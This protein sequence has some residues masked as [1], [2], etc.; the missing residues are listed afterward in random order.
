[1]PLVPTADSPQQMG[2]ETDIAATFEAAIL[3]QPAA[4][5]AP[6]PQ[7][8]ATP[9]PEPPTPAAEPPAEDP[10]PKPEP[11]PDPT[12]LPIDDVE[13]PKPD[14]TPAKDKAGMR[15]EELKKEIATTWKPKAAQLEQDIAAKEARIKELE[16]LA[17]QRDE[18]KAKL[19][20]HE[21]EMAVISLE[22][23]EA[24]QREVGGPLNAIETRATELA[25]QY[26]LDREKMFEAFATTDDAAR[27]TL[28]REMLSGVEMDDEDRFELR[29]L[30]ADAQPILDRKAALYQNADAALA[31]FQA[32]TE[33]QQLAA[34]AA[35]AEER[36]SIAP[37]ITSTLAKWLP[38]LREV[39]EAAAAKVAKTDPS[40]HP[41][42]HRVYHA[43]A[44]DVLPV[45]G[46]MY[47][48][49]KAE[50]D[51]L[52]DEVR[53]ARSANPGIDSLASGK[54]ERPADPTQAFL[55]GMGAL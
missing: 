53:S 33:K 44:G 54:P 14:D 25:S 42:R 2:G 8:P 22:K 13:P 34:A 28:I 35:A 41:T 4:P 9:E 49:L 20:A 37:E 7:A 52:L 43:M 29:K 36:A 30:I 27:K 55:Q 24:Y 50:H 21:K 19:E 46:K 6:E 51:L 23:T 3:A 39:S 15:I 16:G 48:K 1:M 38:D 47:A 5:A 45:L 11:E 32:M 26:S 40:A 18:F 17:A 31:E 12:K 10:V